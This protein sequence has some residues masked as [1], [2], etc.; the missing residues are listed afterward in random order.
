MLTQ[1]PIPHPDTHWAHTDLERIDLSK[2]GATEA[3]LVTEA[4]DW[5]DYFASSALYALLV[6]IILWRLP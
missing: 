6:L 4:A 3:L 5:F 2:P 1:P